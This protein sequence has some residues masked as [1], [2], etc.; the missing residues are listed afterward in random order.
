MLYGHY[1]FAKEASIEAI[2]FHLYSRKQSAIVG[3]T[4]KSVLMRQV[5]SSHSLVLQ[6]AGQTEWDNNYIIPFCL[7]SLSRHKTVTYYK[8]NSIHIHG[9]SVVW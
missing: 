5:K 2:L 6:Q 7:P 1:A 9:K 8:D 3:S 4:G